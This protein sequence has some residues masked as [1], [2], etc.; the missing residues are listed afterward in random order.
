VVPIPRAAAVRLYEKSAAARWSVPPAALDA[1][2]AAS[3]AR[4]FAG[5]DPSEREVERYLASLHV[6]DLALALACA[7]GHDEAWNT[8]VRTM[9]PGLYRAA[10]ALDAS[11]GARETA[12]ALYADLFG[13]RERDGRRESLL[14]HYHGRSSLA[15]WLRAVLAQR[16]VDR[17]RLARRLEPL[18]EDD[19]L[20]RAPE[21]P[22]PDR[23]RQ[24]RRLQSALGRAVAALDP[25]DR[26]RLACYY[27][28]QLTLAATGRI[29]GEHEATVSRQLARTRRAIRDEVER[30]LRADGLGDEEIDECF[31]AIVEDP[32]R[33]DLG[34][35]LGKESVPDRSI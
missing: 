26:L 22:D 2:L 16:H 20:P 14:R 29:L 25:R 27:A 13:T 34:R 21:T 11:G 32:G 7:A 4:A 31:A 30:L 5:R 9:R 12:D 33:F 23:E 17:I 19:R 24:Q 35:V 18:P 1:A 3:V 15:T 10:D 28:R 8:F 6:E